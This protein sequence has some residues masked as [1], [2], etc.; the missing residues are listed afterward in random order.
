LLVIALER[1]EAAATGQG[2]E[3]IQHAAAV[4]PPVDVVAQGNERILRVGRDGIEQGVE[5]VEAAV[6]VADGDGTSGHAASS[7]KPQTFTAPP[8]PGSRSAPAGRV[9]R[10]PSPCR[11]WTG[12]GRRPGRYVLQISPPACPWRS[13][14]A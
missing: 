8:G 13:P 10:S 7:E 5:R 4:R 14:T 2:E 3:P 11:P 9:R 1:D 6:D 12:R